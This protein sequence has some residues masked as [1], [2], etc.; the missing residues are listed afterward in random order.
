MIEGQQADAM[1]DADVPGALADG[2]EENFGSG[3]VRVFLQE[4]VLDLPD[5]VETDTVGQFDLC[6]CF[7]INVALAQGVPRT[8]RLLS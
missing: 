8:R 1:G 4:V 5:V 6:E 3:T 2:A 7:T